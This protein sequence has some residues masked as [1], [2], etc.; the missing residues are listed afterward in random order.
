MYNITITTPLGP[1]KACAHDQAVY[2]LAFTD[3][4]APDN[5]NKILQQLKQEL[6]AYFAGTL[7]KFTVPL[8]LRGTPFQKKVWQALLTIPAGTTVSYAQIAHAIGQPTA[9]RAVA[10]ANKANPIAIIVPCHRVIK[11]NGDLCGYNGGVER[12]AWLLEHEGRT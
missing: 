3:T 10:L 6:D 8:D 4:A 1:L 11:A 5:P 7:K 12:K 9:F 2:R